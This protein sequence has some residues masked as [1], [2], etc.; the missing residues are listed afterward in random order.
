[1]LVFRTQLAQQMTSEELL[2]LIYPTVRSASITDF[3]G[4]LVLRYMVA[5]M[6]AGV[7]LVG[8]SRKSV[9]EAFQKVIG[10]LYEALEEENGDLVGAE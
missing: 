8:Q 2:E 5:V 7:W 6:D 3:P 4:S 9:L 10:T 1:M